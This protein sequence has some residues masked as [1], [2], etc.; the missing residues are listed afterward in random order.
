[1]SKASDLR[2]KATRQAEIEMVGEVC[3]IMFHYWGLYPDIQGEDKQSGFRNPLIQK[4]YDDAQ[5]LKSKLANKPVGV[6][7]E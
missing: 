2:G 1:M 5:S 3:Q 7:N 6:S 4:L